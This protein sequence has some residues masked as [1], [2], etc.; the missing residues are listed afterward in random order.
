MRILV[1]SYPRCGSTMLFR[2]IAG[3]P[4]GSTT[5]KGHPDICQLLFRDPMK[6]SAG[7]EE[8]TRLPRWPH[9]CDF[10]H[11]PG[12]PFLK[13]HSPAPAMLP[14]D[15][16]AIYTFADPVSAVLSMTQKRW[17]RLSWFAAGYRADEPPA[18]FEEDAFGFERVFESWTGPK[19][20]RVLALRYETLWQ[21]RKIL[22]DY[23]G[24]RIVLPRRRA[25]TTV[26][27]PELERRLRDVYGS[28]IEKVRSF[29]DAKLIET[30]NAGSGRGEW[31]E[32]IPPR[33]WPR[34]ENAHSFRLEVSRGMAHIIASVGAEA[35]FRA[36]YLV[37]RV[38][39]AL[40]RGIRSLLRPL[41]P[42][43]VLHKL[44][45]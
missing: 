13:T 6:S 12:A 20:Y 17:D 44:G 7:N 1:A 29:P 43:A 41:W 5:P 35:C 11:M 42:Q 36:L 2:A 45:L 30:M 19:P 18:I 31:V 8:L 28:L 37:P 21:H 10:A 34:L 23:L 27:P 33:L 39:P 40:R 15:V 9:V 3:L 32:Y 38:R 24:R 26:V 25:R 16:R 22:E 14:K 4:P